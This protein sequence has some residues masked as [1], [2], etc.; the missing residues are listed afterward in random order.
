MERTTEPTNTLNTAFTSC[1]GHPMADSVAG[2]AVERSLA[3]GN[4][5]VR[6]ASSKRPTPN[7]PTPKGES[8]ERDGQKSDRT[9]VRYVFHPDSSRLRLSFGSWEVGSWALSEL[10]RATAVATNE[11]GDSRPGSIDGRSRRVHVSLKGSQRCAVSSR[12][13]DTPSA[14]CCAHRDSRSLRR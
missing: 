3:S 4:E 12:T 6:L 5:W 14:C 2:P 9:A 8:I 13:S 10:S 7:C 11:L 1:R